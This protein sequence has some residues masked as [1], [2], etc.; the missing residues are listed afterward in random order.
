MV[1]ISSYILNP[2]LFIWFYAFAF[3]IGKGFMYS[4]ALYACWSHVPGK[5]GLATGIAVSGFGFGGFIFGIITNNLCNPDNIEVQTY[6]VNNSEQRF[7]PQEVS[8]N[9]PD[10]L[11]RL[12]FIWICVFLFGVITISEYKGEV[13]RPNEQTQNLNGSNQSL[14]SRQ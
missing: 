9:V 12:D 13:Y 7:F 3:G 4:S 5:I 14:L 11:R 6:T 10:M 2:Y 8:D 1:Y